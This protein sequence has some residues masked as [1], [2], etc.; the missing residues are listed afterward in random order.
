MLN[1]A[2]DQIIRG[3]IYFF[4]SDAMAA[5]SQLLIV[6]IKAFVPCV[7]SGKALHHR[8]SLRAEY[9]VLCEHIF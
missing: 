4:L 5:N 1:G 8:L 3:T 7:I 6:L 2:V 9:V